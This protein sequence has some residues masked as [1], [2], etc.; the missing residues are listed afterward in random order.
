MADPSFYVGCCFHVF[1][2]GEDLGVFGQNVT[3][4]ACDL[5]SNQL[6]DTLTLDRVRFWTKVLY[7]LGLTAIQSYLPGRLCS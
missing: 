2:V 3:T 1:V 4:M 7:D 5:K 6:Y